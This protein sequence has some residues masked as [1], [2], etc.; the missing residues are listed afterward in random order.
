MKYTACE[1]TLINKKYVYHLSSIIFLCF[2][3]IVYFRG[4]TIYD[5]YIKL[6]GNIMK[7]ILLLAGILLTGS[8]LLSI[9]A[10][11]G[12]DRKE[13]KNYSDNIMRLLKENRIK[14]AFAIMKSIWPMPESDVDILEVQ[15]TK[16]LEV[17]KERFGSTLEYV[18]VE[19]KEI[20]DTFFKLVYVIK[21]ERHITRWEFIYYKPK[22]KCLL[23]SIKLDD[24]I[25]KLF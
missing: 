8:S 18:L 6:W 20:K 16:R 1:P 12:I 14:D 7:W 5:Y 17:V 4:I 15:T 11:T 13:L 2:K 22:T 3:I 9:E 25:G 21:Y 24:D 10:N 23:N 19:E